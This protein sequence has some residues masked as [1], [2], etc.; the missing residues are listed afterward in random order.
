MCCPAG[1]DDGHNTHGGGTGHRPN[2]LGAVVQRF[3]NQASL[4]YA[5]KYG[6]TVFSGL[7]DD[8]QQAYLTELDG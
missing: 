4:R 6:G 2:S 7:A 5:S 1:A 3:D 8:L